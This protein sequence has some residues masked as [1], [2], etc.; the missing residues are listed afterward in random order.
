MIANALGEG[1]LDFRTDPARLLENLYI[2][3]AKP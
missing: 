3:S 1:L 2:T